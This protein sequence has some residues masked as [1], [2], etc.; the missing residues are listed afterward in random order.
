[1]LIVKQDTDTHVFHA[2]VASATALCVVKDAKRKSPELVE[3]ERLT[4]AP[5]SKSVCGEG[6]R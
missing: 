5:I 6:P 4:L 1:M 3:R 2:G